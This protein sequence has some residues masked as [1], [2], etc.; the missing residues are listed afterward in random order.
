MTEPIIIASFGLKQLISLASLIVVYRGNKREL[1][2]IQL[3][4]VLL[5][6]T[7]DNFLD[8]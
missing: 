5:A 7:S 4:F 1:L 6:A 8:L 2:Q 3:N